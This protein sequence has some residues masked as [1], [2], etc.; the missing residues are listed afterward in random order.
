MIFETDEVGFIYP[1]SKSYGGSGNPPFK[2]LEEIQSTMIKKWKGGSLRRFVELLNDEFAKYNLDYEDFILEDLWIRA[3]KSDLY[4]DA[5]FV[6]NNNDDYINLGFW[7]ETW[8]G[9]NY[10]ISDDLDNY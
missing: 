1:Q 10:I 4:F 3:Y 5:K 2:V 7:F 8:D 6:A 9:K